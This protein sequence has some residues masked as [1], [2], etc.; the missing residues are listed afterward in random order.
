MSDLPRP[1][2]VPVRFPLVLCLLL[3]AANATIAT[4]SLVFVPMNKRVEE[5]DLIVIGRVIQEA[6]NRY[7]SPV[8]AG[9]GCG[10]GEA[11]VTVI[12]VLRG[13]LEG[14]QARLVGNSYIQTIRVRHYD[15][16]TRDDGNFH[17]ILISPAYKDRLDGIWFLQRSDAPGVYCLFDVP[18]TLDHRGE[19]QSSLRQVFTEPSTPAFK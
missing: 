10:R 16:L 7:K 1:E 17:T 6:P 12:E 18:A 19:V 15:T 8:A 3:I 14:S 4:A 13:T 11:V 5:S 9:K 2:G